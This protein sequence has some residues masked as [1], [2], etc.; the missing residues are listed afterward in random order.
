M[1]IRKSCDCYL[2]EGDPIGL[3]ALSAGCT[4]LT[5]P[6]YPDISMIDALFHYGPETKY[7]L[8]FSHAPSSHS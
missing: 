7:R 6:P 5:Y 2:T 3:T 1:L 4:L 8:N